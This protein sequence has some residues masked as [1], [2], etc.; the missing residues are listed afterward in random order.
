MKQINCMPF[1]QP[2]L[3]QM[4]FFLHACFILLIYALFVFAMPVSSFQA[5]LTPRYSMICIA[6]NKKAAL[7][8]PL[9]LV[10]GSGLRGLNNLLHQKIHNPV[11]RQVRADLLQF[12]DS[13]LDRTPRKEIDQDLQCR[14]V[15]QFERDLTT[16]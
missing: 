6:M 10:A 15:A 12:I 2:R 7:R 16:H 5:E 13:L 9:P 3:T 11:Q 14:E 8:R 4:R 1:P